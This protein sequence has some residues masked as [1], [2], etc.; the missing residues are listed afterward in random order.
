MCRVRYGEHVAVWEY[1]MTHVGI[2]PEGSTW[3][4]KARFALGS[5]HS[6]DRSLAEDLVKRKRTALVGVCEGEGVWLLSSSLIVKP[7][8]HAVDLGFLTC[9]FVQVAPFL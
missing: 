1:A 4:K 8:F 2:T 7:A 3:L 5:L 9:P 6:K